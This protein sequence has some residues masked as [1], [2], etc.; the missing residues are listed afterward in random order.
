LRLC[1]F[2]FAYLLLESLRRLLLSGTELA[3]ATVGSIRLN[4]LEI[5]AVITVSV[6]RVKAAMS[7]AFP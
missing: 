1:L 3:H 7:S 6:R 5:G 4:L 2:S